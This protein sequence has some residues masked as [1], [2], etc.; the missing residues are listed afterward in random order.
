LQSEN[1]C[2]IIKEKYF[3]NNAIK[4]QMQ[5]NKRIIIYKQTQS[6]NRCT[7]MRIGIY[8]KQIGNCLDNLILAKQA[9]QFMKTLF[10]KE[11]VK[12]ESHFSQSKPRR[13]YN[14]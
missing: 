10:M 11:T 9:P 5:Q 6:E 2:T 14:I 1:R 3:R 7:K 4:R 8:T 12:K 13:P